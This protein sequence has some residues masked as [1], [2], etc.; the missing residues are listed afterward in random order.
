MGI[1]LAWPGH[2]PSWR[3]QVCVTV[4]QRQEDTHPAVGALQ[5]CQQK[6]GGN[7]SVLT[8]QPAVKSIL[9]GALKGLP[10]TGQVSGWGRRAPQNIPVL[11]VVL[12]EFH[13]Q[14]S[15]PLDI[16]CFTTCL[17]PSLLQHVMTLLKQTQWERISSLLC[18][19]VSESF[20]S[21][22]KLL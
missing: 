14:C 22:K 20:Q 4:L 16:P 8:L 18:K 17:S 3:V 1:T 11:W 21:W 5:H 15:Y 19:N 10:C 13:Y 7:P 12:E 9:T 2:L 6:R